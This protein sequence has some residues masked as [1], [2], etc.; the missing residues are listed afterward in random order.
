MP[1]DLL[2][3]RVDAQRQRRAVN[4]AIEIGHDR[5]VMPFHILEEDRLVRPVLH[6]LNHRSELEVPRIHRLL[7]PDQFT[8]AL[9]DLDELPQV[10]GN[11]L[12]SIDRTFP[13]G[14][15]RV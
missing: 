6:E 12:R 9:Q 2:R 13:G 5:Q 11:R 4:R 14:R 7:D 15:C 8:L 10:A 1:F 3:C